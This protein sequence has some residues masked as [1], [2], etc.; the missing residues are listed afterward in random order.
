MYP[1]KENN[2]ILRI[3]NLIK[4]IESLENQELIK[5]MYNIV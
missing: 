3:S 4:N 2:K 1:I 5:S